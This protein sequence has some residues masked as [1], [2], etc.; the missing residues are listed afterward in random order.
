MYWKD[1]IPEYIEPGIIIDQLT[2]LVDDQDRE[3]DRL[4]KREIE[5]LNDGIEHSKEMMG[6]V[7][8][9]MLD[10]PPVRTDRKKDP[11]THCDECGLLR[12]DLKNERVFRVP[13]TNVQFRIFFEYRVMS[14]SGGCIGIDQSHFCKRCTHEALSMLASELE[15]L[16]GE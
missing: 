4:R 14:G 10:K 2:R 16:L 6:N 5:L 7:L 1:R 11:K 3:I 9:A 13:D 15:K 12:Q 8:V